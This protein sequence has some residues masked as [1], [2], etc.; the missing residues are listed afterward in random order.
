MAKNAGVV[1]L[2][3]YQQPIARLRGVGPAVA[4]KLAA[5][6]LETLQDLWLWLPRG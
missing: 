4:E 1:A 3:P 2:D 5:R 6:G